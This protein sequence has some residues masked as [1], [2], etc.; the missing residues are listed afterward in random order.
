MIEMQPYMMPLSIYKLDQ[1]L[2][3]DMDV[4]TAKNRP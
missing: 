2:N 3:G 1:F 4:P